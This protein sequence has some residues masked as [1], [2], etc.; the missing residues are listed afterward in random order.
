[1]VWEIF[2]YAFLEKQQFL[3]MTLALVLCPQHAHHGLA[4]ITPVQCS[5]LSGY[6]VSSSLWPT[7]GMSATSYITKY[8]THPTAQSPPVVECLKS[9]V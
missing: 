8:I 3:N 7:L 4:L 2:A 6:L 1:M 5:P 9:G